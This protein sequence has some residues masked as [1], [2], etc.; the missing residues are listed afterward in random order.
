MAN[1]RLRAASSWIEEAKRERE[2]E[3]DLLACRH[4]VLKIVRYMKE[5][6][7]SHKELAKKLNVSPQY[8]NKFLHGQDL[9]MKV[10]TVFRYGRILGIKLLELP[11]QNH[12]EETWSYYGYAWMK[13][14][15]VQPACFD[16]SNSLYLTPGFRPNIRKGVTRSGVLV[17]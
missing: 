8:I 10:S 17:S 7:L 15:S 6:H 11:I 12:N 3:E 9:D 4:I 1:G 2:I 13:K 16:Y 14:T 5:N